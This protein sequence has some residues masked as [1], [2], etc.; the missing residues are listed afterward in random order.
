MIDKATREALTNVIRAAQAALDGAPIQK[1]DGTS[2]I[3]RV[4]QACPIGEYVTLGTIAYA[5]GCSTAAASAR[6]RDLRK[7]GFKVETRRP[8]GGG[9]YEYKVGFRA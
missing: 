3:E 2:Q 5:A 1:T 7:E 8:V 4:F 9:S 6:L